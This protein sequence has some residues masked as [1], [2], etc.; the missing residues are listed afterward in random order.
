VITFGN[1]T[2]SAPRPSAARPRRGRTGSRR[3]QAFVAPLLGRRLVGDHDRDFTEGRRE[4]HRNAAS[5][6][7]TRSSN[8]AWRLAPPVKGGQLGSRDPAVSLRHGEPILRRDG[9]RARPATHGPRVAGPGADP[10]PPPLPAQIAEP[11]G[12]MSR[13][14]ARVRIHFLDWGGPTTGTR[15]RAGVHSVAEAGEC[16]A[17]VVTTAAS[18]ASC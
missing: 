13:W 1:G 15:G 12:F 6:R 5:A 10:F 2:S 8:G 16:P 11:A 9:R 14:T 3:A 18:P 7:S 4:R 17:R